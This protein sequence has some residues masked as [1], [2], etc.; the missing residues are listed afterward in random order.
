ME[1]G[2]KGKRWLIPLL[3]AAAV[4]GAGGGFAYVHFANASPK[5][6]P[7]VDVSLGEFTTN[8]ADA[9]QRRIIQIQVT[10]EAAGAEG[11][12]LLQERQAAIQDAVTRTLRSFR[13]DDLAGDAGADRLKAALLPAINGAAGKPVVRAVFLTRMVIQ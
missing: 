5:E 1:K 7:G 6:V 12:K 3:L 10:V 8:L 2:K 13:A 4:L 11:Q 9:D